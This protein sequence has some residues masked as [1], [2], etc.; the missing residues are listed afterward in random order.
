MDILLEMAWR[1]Y[2]ESCQERR[3]LG[4]AT[5][6][7][8]AVDGVLLGICFQ[9]P[10]LSGW[11]LFAIAAISTIFAVLTFVGQRYNVTD[12]IAIWRELSTEAMTKDD[13]QARIISAICAI[14]KA[15]TEK[16][17]RLWRPLGLSIAELTS[18]LIF[19][20]LSLL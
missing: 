10:D 13:F 20:A 12:T 3:D 16:T 4:V 17:Q 18:A 2:D 6:V 1:R 19:L 8:L 5:G 14:E 7:I 11:V 15:N 9:I